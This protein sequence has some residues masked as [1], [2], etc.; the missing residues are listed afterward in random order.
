MKRKREL[1][2]INDPETADLVLSDNKGQSIRVHKSLLANRSEYFAELFRSNNKASDLEELQ[3]DENNLIDLIHYLYD[4]EDVD[5]DA[6]DDMADD[7][8]LNGEIEI[9]M[10]LLALAKKYR[11]K[12]LYTNLSSEINLKLKAETAVE[13]YRCSKLLDLLDIVE[14]CKPL[15][16]SWLPIIQMTSSF[17]ELLAADIYDIFTSEKSDIDRECKLNALSLWWSHNKDKDIT[18]LWTSLVGCSNQQ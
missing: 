13:I 12:Q 1:I 3:L 15:I 4:H 6:G 17:K 10:R 8:L 7:D 14:T 11:F 2:T 18:N 9:L 5:H 16:L